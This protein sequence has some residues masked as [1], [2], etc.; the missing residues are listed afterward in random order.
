MITNKLY[1]TIVQTVFI[2][3]K[4][5]SVSALCIADIHLF[6]ND[7]SDFLLN[8]MIVFKYWKNIP[9]FFMLFTNVVVTNTT[10]F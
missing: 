4:H 10:H 6:I 5:L 1:F 7:V 8:Q 2:K 3:L 9:L